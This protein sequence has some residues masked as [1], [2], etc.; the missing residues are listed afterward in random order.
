MDPIKKIAFLCYEE[1]LAHNSN[2]GY[3]QTEYFSNA[4][5]ATGTV[6]VARFAWDDA[7]VD[8]SQYAMIFPLE[9]PFMCL[10]F[11]LVFCFFF[12]K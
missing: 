11:R 4:L 8:L 7:S 3:S 10:H 1:G 6:D 12:V 9:V 2:A 5:K